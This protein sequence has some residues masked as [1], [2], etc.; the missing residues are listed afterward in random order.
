MTPEHMPLAE[1]T[2]A[3][4]HSNEP[5]FLLKFTTLLETNNRFLLC[6]LEVSGGSA[7]GTPKLLLDIHLSLLSVYFVLR[8]IYFFLC[9]G[10]GKIFFSAV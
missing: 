7:V 6:S 3:T 2:V 8:D 9:S 4:I 10:D 5:K 1:L